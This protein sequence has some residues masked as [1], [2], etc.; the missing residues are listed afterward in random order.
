MSDSHWLSLINSF[1]CDEKY[2]GI[3][4]VSLQNISF[5]FTSIS[6]S[7]IYVWNSIF[8]ETLSNISLK[9]EEV[10]SFIWPYVDTIIYLLKKANLGTNL[11]NKVFGIEA[12]VKMSL[13]QYF[14]N[15]FRVAV[16]AIDPFSACE[17]YI[18]LF[19]FFTQLI[20]LGKTSDN[21]L[22]VLIND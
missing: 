3:S 22:V 18:K 16:Q 6:Q 19:S 11:L 13:E 9:K 10:E 21:K 2:F 4:R 8:N 7:G 1:S 15:F 5:D 20:I 14:V 12:L 17:K